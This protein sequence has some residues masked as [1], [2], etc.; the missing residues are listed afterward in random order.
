V[1]YL[2]HPPTLA[3]PPP[4]SLSIMGERIKEK[5]LCGG[6]LDSLLRQ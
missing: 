1:T 5:G 2:S 3:L 6:W 4:L